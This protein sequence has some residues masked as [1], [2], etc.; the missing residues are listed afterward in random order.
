MTPERRS[1]RR[2]EAAERRAA[3]EAERS[4]KAADPFGVLGLLYDCRRMAGEPRMGTA[5][6][7]VVR[8]CKQQGQRVVAGRV[9]FKEITRLRRAG[10][11]KRGGGFCWLTEE[12]FAHLSDNDNTLVLTPET[13]RSEQ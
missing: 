3:H 7:E 1:K 12:T 2:A 11:I 10:K 6:W 4:R 8:L 5:E 9:I 13:Q